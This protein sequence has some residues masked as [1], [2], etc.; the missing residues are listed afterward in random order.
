M[1][2]LD[3]RSGTKKSDFNSQCC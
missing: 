1:I 3:I 2:Q